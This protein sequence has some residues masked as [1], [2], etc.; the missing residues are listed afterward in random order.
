VTSADSCRSYL[1]SRPKALTT[2]ALF[3]VDEHLALEFRAPLKKES[4]DMPPP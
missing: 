1:Y 2:P 4:Y 3:G